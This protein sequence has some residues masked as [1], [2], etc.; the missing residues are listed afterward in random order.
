MA[1]PSDL[2]AHYSGQLLRTRLSA[3]AFVGAVLGAD[4]A[5]DESEISSVTLG[6][7]LL[8]V[9]ASLGEMN[10]RYTWSY[11]SACRAAELSLP[12]PSVVERWR[13]FREMNEGP[14]APGR[15]SIRNLPKWLL[16]TW[17]RALGNLRDPAHLVNRY[18]LSWSTYFPGIAAGW[19]L[20]WCEGSVE[21]SNTALGISGG[22]A[23]W[24]ALQ[25]VFAVDPLSY[26]SKQPASE[27]GTTRKDPSPEA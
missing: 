6:Y 7:A 12:E 11:L 3:L 25:V 9:V 21:Q 5:W 16:R 22:L 15:L 10:R 8:V 18:L 23:V 24:W 2:V 14:W 13:A 1:E 17:R 4:A 20:V 26:S 19:Y 27:S